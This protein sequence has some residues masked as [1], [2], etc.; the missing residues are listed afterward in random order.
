MTNIGRPADF[1]VAIDSTMVG[2]YSASAKA[3][4]G[5]VWDSVLEY[6]VWCHP[7]HG[8]ADL[9]EGGDYFYAFSTFDAAAEFAAR[10]PGSDLPL[11][12]VLQK[13]YLD[14]PEPGQFVHVRTERIAEWPPEF[15]R[16]PVR[17]ERMIPD[18]LAEDAPP[19]RLDILRGL[20]AKT[21]C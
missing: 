12:L 21:Q 10:T 4:G 9:A 8:S 13:E 6:R 2:T 5:Y 7:E 19:N 1:P 20:A 16:R 14:E 3:G 11:A 18:F 17:D 15:L